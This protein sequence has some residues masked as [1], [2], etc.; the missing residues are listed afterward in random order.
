ML[1]SSIFNLSWQA[2]TATDTAGLLRGLCLGWALIL[3]SKDTGVTQ[4]KQEFQ[5]WTTG[6]GL[7]IITFNRLLT[8]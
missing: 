7:W 6:T 2:V 8:S 3:L 5:S 1:V 4:R